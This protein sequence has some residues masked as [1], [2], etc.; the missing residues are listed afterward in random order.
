LLSTSTIAAQKNALVFLTDFGTR[1]G[2]VAAMKGVA[3]G[4]DSSLPMFD[5][6]HEI[7][8]FNIWEAAYRL[9]QTASFWPAG[10]V[11]VTVVDPGVG[12]NRRSVV[13]KSKSGHF[14]VGPDNGIFTLI[15]EQLGIEEIRDIDSRLN[16]MK[17]NE[18]SHT[19]DGRDLFVYVSARL[20]AGRMDLSEVGPE[21]LNTVFSIPYQKATIDSGS[22][23]GAIPVLDVQ[24]GNVWTNIP[25]DMI[26][27]IGI[28]KG[29]RL[30]IQIYYRGAEKYSG[31]IP[32]VNSF[33]DVP[34]GR[35]LAYVN[36][37]INIGLA[38]NRGSFADKHHIG[39]GADWKVVLTKCRPAGKK[40]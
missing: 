5:L 21:S 35:P 2:A 25:G 40:N 7:Q 31:E 28:E 13:L 15:A 4:V 27:R 10:T 33:S 11:F 24:F 3:Y 34:V 32:F 16:R 30:C 23:Y 8:P 36:S 38:L 39:A 26:R 6:T 12:S 37:L 14:F 22:I 29:D 20:A 1:D 17:G 9:Y 18:Q 19:F